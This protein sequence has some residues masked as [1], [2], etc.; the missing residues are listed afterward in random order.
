MALHG[1]RDDLERWARKGEPGRNRALNELEWQYEAPKLPEAYAYTIPLRRS[2][3]ARE[4]RWQAGSLAVV[5][6]DSADQ[7]PIA[8]ISRA[9][10]STRTTMIPLASSGK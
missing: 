3:L 2:G 9:W 4:G 8:S 6:R 1:L 7:S 5:Y 10:W